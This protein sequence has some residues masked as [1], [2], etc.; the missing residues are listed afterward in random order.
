MRNHVLRN[1][2]LFVC[3]SLIG[4]TV[5]AQHRFQ[6]SLPAVSDSGYYKVHLPPAITAKARQDL[7]DIRILEKETGRQVPYILKK[8]SGVINEKEFKSFHLLPS[9]LSP[10]SNTQ[11]VMHITEAVR[12]LKPADDYS[13]IFIMKR[14]AAYR[15]AVIGGS[16][17]LTSWYAVADRILLDGGGNGT[18]ETHLQAVSIPLGK[19]QYL[20]L[21]MKDKGMQPLQ[22][23]NAGISLNSNIFGRY[24]ELPSP[25]IHQ[26]DSSNKSSYIRLQFNECY[27]ISKLRI[28]IRQPALYKRSTRLYA[29]HNNK[30]VY[31]TSTVLEPGTDSIML[32]AIKS[33]EMLLELQNF[34]N[35]PL[36]IT[37]VKAF[38]L[39]QYLVAP[40]KPSTDY[41][42]VMGDENAQAPI[43]DLAYFANSIP[44]QATVLTPSAPES[45]QQETAPA[46]KEKG[47]SAIWLW[48]III[49]ALLCLLWM[50][51]GL[52]QEISKNKHS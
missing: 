14:A 8:E 2:W 3:F 40:F 50:S 4:L 39:Q 31:I 34:D 19:Y 41:L 43:Y 26:S 10:D 32:P 17:D 49:F 16:D 27:P 44:L 29:I 18:E 48:V 45:L 22:I 38:Q 42:M 36:E 1:N 28:P 13:V 47:L 51:R 6:A 24:E 15:E 7:A 37:A 21:M 23:V 25:Y 46:T 20:R 5:Q 30:Q 35:P 52:I 12:Q 9:S 33:K 11:I